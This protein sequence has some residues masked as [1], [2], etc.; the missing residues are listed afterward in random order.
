MPDKIDTKNKSV[1]RNE[2]WDGYGYAVF[3]NDICLLLACDCEDLK[4]NKLWSLQWTQR[5]KVDLQIIILF[6]D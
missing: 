6:V 4:M 2:E 1:Q 5:R 3:E